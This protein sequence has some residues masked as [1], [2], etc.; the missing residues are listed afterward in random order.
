MR[1][2]IDLCVLSSQDWES[3]EIKEV[4]PRS[5]NYW[6]FDERRFKGNTLTYASTTELLQKFILDS[7]ISAIICPPGVQLENDKAT[8]PQTT[9]IY[10]HKNPRE[11]FFLLHEFLANRI[12]DQ[13]SMP[14]VI[15]KDCQI[16]PRAE[17]S[18]TDVVIG[19]NVV[20]EG[21]CVI[22]PGV[23]IGS[24]SRIGMGST[25]GGAGFQYNRGSDGTLSLVSHIGSVLIE[26]DVFLHS[27][28][29]VDKAIF[30]DETRVGRGSKIDAHV[31]VSHAARVGEDCLIAPG[32]VICGAVFI[33]DRTWIGPNSTVRDTLKVGSE[34]AISLGAVV[35]KN[36]QDNERV[37]GNFARP[38]GEFLK[39]LRQS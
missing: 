27:T 29:N 10:W 11:G 16:S 33:G 2:P 1:T 17:I 34:A 26:E 24:H 23:T 30:L 8:T 39:T 38:H 5:F 14:T 15:G 22:Q 6:D 35:T 32:A 18:A 31:Q 13:S 19:D 25:L 28:V 3:L 9:G 20:I 7:R 12:T 36:V 37:S 4:I 21:G